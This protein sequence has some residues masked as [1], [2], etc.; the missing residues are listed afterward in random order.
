MLGPLIFQ[1][2]VNG[3]SKKLEDEIDVG[4][5]ADDIS[6]ICKFECNEKFPL[7]IEK[8]NRTNRQTLD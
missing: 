5:F 4:Q 7:K 8:S 6:F 1:L 2:Y 3:F